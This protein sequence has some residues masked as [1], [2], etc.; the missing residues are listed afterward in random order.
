MSKVEVIK[1]KGA[2]T[3]NY[4][5]I[6]IIIIAIIS[7]VCIGIFNNIDSFNT[8]N[9]NNTNVNN[10]TV[11]N[12]ETLYKIS[13]DN[14]DYFK[15]STISFSEKYT[16]KL[17][18]ESLSASVSF[19]LYNDD[20]QKDQCYYSSQAKFN[21]GSLTTIQG[22]CTYNVSNN[23]LTVNGTFNK[24]EIPSSYEQNMGVPSTNSK[25]DAHIECQINGNGKS[26]TCGKIT[27]YNYSYSEIN[28]RN[29]D[30]FLIDKKHIIY[31]EYGVGI[32]NSEYTL[33]LDD[34]EIKE[35]TSMPY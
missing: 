4:I 6:G 25:E 31:D 29:S 15:E 21:N 2:G 10:N 3:P 13:V 18:G 16:A 17:D 33:N 19:M 5:W 22:K 14:F 23:I 12:K 30:Y 9:D 32:G 26:I 35:V 1:S 28:K 20:S 27:Y 24:L 34:Y 11:K 7:G 8:D